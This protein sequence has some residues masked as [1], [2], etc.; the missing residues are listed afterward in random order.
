LGIYHEEEK[1]ISIVV[2]AN[3]LQFPIDTAIPLG[4]MITELITNSLQ[5]ALEDQ[6]D[7]AIW[8]TIQSK[9]E[10]HFE[11]VYSDNGEERFLATYEEDM[12]LSATLIQLLAQQLEGAVK[13]VRGPSVGYL[14]QFKAA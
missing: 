13:N 11:L 9:E 4:L 1:A 14:I 5:Y 2:K 10:G 7:G 8:I 6:T 3:K 12:H